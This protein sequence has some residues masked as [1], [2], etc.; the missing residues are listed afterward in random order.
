[1]LKLSFATQIIAYIVAKEILKAFIEI[2]WK[3]F[4]YS[5][6]LDILLL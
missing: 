2:Q 5:N 1:M 4:Y 3:L 6:G